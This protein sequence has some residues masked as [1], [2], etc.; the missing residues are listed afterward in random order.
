MHATTMVGTVLTVS[1]LAA[2][3]V[4]DDQEFLN[5]T[6]R[7]I[8]EADGIKSCTA[9]QLENCESGQN[10]SSTGCERR[11]WVYHENYNLTRLFGNDACQTNRIS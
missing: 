4:G 1:F 5:E 2:V 3:C 7:V 11:F 10:C 6:A 8:N 9:P